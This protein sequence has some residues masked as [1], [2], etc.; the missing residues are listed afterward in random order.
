MMPMTLFES[1]DSTG[2]ISLEAL[3]GKE[4]FAASKADISGRFDLPYC[5]RRRNPAKL[6]L[7]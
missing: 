7:Y 3:F 6:K 5:P 4:K 1:G 2:K